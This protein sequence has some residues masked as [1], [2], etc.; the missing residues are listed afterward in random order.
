[1]SL[2]DEVIDAHGLERLPARLLGGG[3]AVAGVKLLA[4]PG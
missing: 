3:L 1:M 2:V 4:V